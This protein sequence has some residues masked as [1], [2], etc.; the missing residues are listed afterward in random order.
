LIVT[1][2]VAS[3]A[4]AGAATRS[5]LGALT[6]GAPLHLAGDLLPHREIRSRAFETTTGV[7]AVLL[8]AARWG[9]F[10]PV[11]L[12][13]V[14]AAAPDLEHVLPLPRPGGRSLF[15]SHRYP[16]LHRAGGIAPWAQLLLAGVV[17]AAL[18]RGPRRRA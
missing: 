4:L 16:S 18:A 1:L 8:L 11:T 7:G 6:L 17:L 9:P 10:D 12:G 13:A 14:S 3:G 15:P 5:R 2:H